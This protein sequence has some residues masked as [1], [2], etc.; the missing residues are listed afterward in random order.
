MNAEKRVEKLRRKRR[1]S[2]RREQRHVS[3]AL[4]NEQAVAKLAQGERSDVSDDGLDLSFAD[5]PLIKFLIR[6]GRY[7][8]HCQ[9]F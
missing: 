9:L 7:Q 8:P 2:I 1:D 4:K 3:L 5:N 6:I